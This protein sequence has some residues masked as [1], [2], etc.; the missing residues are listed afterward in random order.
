MEKSGKQAPAAEKI[1]V[2]NEMRIPADPNRAGHMPLYLIPMVSK[3]FLIAS[4]LS[5]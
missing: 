2:K 3:I 4:L 1:A 5:P